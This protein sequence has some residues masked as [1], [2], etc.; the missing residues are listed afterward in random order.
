MHTEL[1]RFVARGRDAAAFARSAHRYRLPTQLRTVTLFDGCV[2]R[3]HIDM[4]DFARPACLGRGFFR[5]L[6]H[7]H[8]NPS[9]PIVGEARM[10][11]ASTACWVGNRWRRRTPA[12]NL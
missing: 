12:A 5:A 3:I 11:F 2:E 6:F 7:P 9:L 10:R 4:D 1:A 8:V